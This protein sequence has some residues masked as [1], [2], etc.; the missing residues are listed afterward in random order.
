VYRKG[1]EVNTVL[2]DGTVVPIKGW[3]F[4][5][6]AV[7]SNGFTAALYYLSGKFLKVVPIWMTKQAS[8]QSP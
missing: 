5:E 7:D 1:V 8:R 6:I 3:L 4:F 2:Y